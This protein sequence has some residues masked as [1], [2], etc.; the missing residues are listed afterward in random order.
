VITTKNLSDRL[1]VCGQPQ[2]ADFESLSASGVTRV[3]CNRPDGEEVGQPTMD[4]I[5]QVLSAQGIE[6]FRYPVN[7]NT[8]PGSDL[9]A[10]AEAFDAGD[11]KILAFC[12]TGTR[13]AN[14]WVVTRAPDE[15]GAAMETARSA[16]FE[17]N[18]ASR[19][20]G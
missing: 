16:G 2:L 4:D 8:F 10:M 19:V 1:L 20:I 14:L 13:S 5:E 11:G 7:P 12:R 17:M 6:F 15:Q 18:L 9:A 3:I